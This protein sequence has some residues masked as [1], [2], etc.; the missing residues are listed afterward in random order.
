MFSFNWIHATILQIDLQINVCGFM[1]LQVALIHLH[2]IKG[3]SMLRS[4]RSFWGFLQKE[5]QKLKPLFHF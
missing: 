1:Y 2:K 3:Y 5:K 4:D